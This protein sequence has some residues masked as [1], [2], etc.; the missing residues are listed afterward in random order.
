VPGELE[1][2][3]ER[4]A[5]HRAAAMAHVHRAG[6]VGRDIFDVDGRA[7]AHGRAAII[8]AG[9][10][11]R[12]QLAAPGVVGQRQVDEARAGDRDRGDLVELLQLGADLLGQRARIGAGR[13]GEHHRGVGR[14]VAM[15][16]VA[17]RLHR[18]RPSLQSR[19]QVAGEDERIQGKVQMRGEACVKCHGRSVM[20]GKRAHLG[21]RCGFVHR[22]GHVLAPRH[23]C[24]HI[25]GP[26]T[27]R[28][29][30]PCE[31]PGSWP[32]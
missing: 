26:G 6:R 10:E 3:G 24:A 23:R 9:V 29:E 1:Q 31:Q 4:I 16:R 21:L 8:V 5:H 18:D 7:G 12:R 17:R 32:R 20:V 30:C 11:D 19:G 15:R 27:K 28:I 22:H 14:Q 2:A 25:C 13:L